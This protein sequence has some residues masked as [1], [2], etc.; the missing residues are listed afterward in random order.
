[1][2]A[3]SNALFNASASQEKLDATIRLVFREEKDKRCD[4]P[5]S[6]ARNTKCP[7]NLNIQLCEVLNV[8]ELDNSKIYC[9]C[10]CDLGFC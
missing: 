9:F 5:V 8:L 3:S 6:S 10:E 2:I 4:F 7:M 1:M